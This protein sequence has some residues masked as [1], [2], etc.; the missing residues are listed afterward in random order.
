[1]LIFY[2]FIYIIF[3][4]SL[5]FYIFYI[6]IYIYFIYLRC[7]HTARHHWWFQL[8][9]PLHLGWFLAVL[10]SLLYLFPPVLALVAP[11]WG[12]VKSVCL[13]SLP[14]YLSAVL[15]VSPCS[16]DYLYTSPQSWFDCADNLNTNITF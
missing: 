4:Y 7:S 14:S 13:P 6:Y 8:L 10:Q 2:I 1:M 16:P 3:I 11:D 15:S 5:I 12:T 9:L